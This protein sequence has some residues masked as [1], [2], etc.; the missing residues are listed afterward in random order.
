[1]KEGIARGDRGA[2]AIKFADLLLQ[3][4]IVEGGLHRRETAGCTQ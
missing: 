2:E 3:A 1:M 4:M